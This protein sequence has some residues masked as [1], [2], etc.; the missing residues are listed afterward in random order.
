MSALRSSAPS[1]SSFTGRTS[2]VSV[3]PSADDLDRQ[4]LALRDVVSTTGA[5]DGALAVRAGSDLRVT[6][7]VRSLIS[8]RTVCG[9]LCEAVADANAAGVVAWLGPTAPEGLYLPAHARVLYVPFSARG[10]SAAALLAVDHPVEFSSSDRRYFQD[11]FTISSA[12]PLPLPDLAR[13]A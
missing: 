7:S 12:R 9:H 11:L 4:L 5:F 6:R 3:V 10:V 8:R 1:T 13:A 2:P